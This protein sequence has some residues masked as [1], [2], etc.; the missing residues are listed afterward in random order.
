MA[1]ISE[2]KVGSLYVLAAG[3][4]TPETL[5]KVVS[6][7]GRWVKVVA[8][9]NGAEANVAAAQLTEFVAPVEVEK[10]EKP[11]R[12]D[13]A[14][15]SNGKVSAERR[16]AYMVTRIEKVRH[17]DCGDELAAHLRGMELEDVYKYAANVMGVDRAALI[18]QYCHLNP[19]MQRMSVGNRL[20]G[21]LGAK[22]KAK[23][24]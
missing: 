16:A 14:L 21:F 5:V 1:N 15:P 20:R 7:K 24:E 2:I 13:G 22:A 10:D 8:E 4:N 19:G 12:K 3:K 6:I 17:V 9:F 23:G 18:A 11:A